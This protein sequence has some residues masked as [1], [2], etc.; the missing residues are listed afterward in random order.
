M[1]AVQIKSYL[2]NT[3]GKTHSGYTVDI[4][5]I[6]KVSR[7]GETERFQKVRYFCSVIICTTQKIELRH[8][9]D[10]Q[11]IHYPCSLLVQE[12]GCF[13]GMVLG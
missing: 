1:S 8:M 12:I 9:I 10:F 5:H 7:H 3:H 11:H 4:V 13:C 2:R 6:F